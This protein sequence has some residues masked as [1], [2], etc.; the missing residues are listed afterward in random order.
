M[1]LERIER[2][3]VVGICTVINITGGKSHGMTLASLSLGLFSPIL[4]NAI[5]I[6]PNHIM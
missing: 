2:E 3:T 1:G 6:I 4:S 5:T